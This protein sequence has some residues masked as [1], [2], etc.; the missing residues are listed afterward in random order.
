MSTVGKKIDG[1]LLCVLHDVVSSNSAAWA[2]AASRHCVAW[3]RTESKIGVMGPDYRYPP[4]YVRFI[5]G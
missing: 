4:V 3:N 1:S 5:A 2:T